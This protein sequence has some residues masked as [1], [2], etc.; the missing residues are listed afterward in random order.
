MILCPSAPLA[1]GALLFGLIDRR[2]H[3]SY[4]QAAVPVTR[5]LLL[6]L[7][8]AESA[9]R[10][11]RFASACDT[12]ACRHWA[13]GCALSAKLSELQVFASDS[14]STTSLPNCSIRTQCRWYLQDG[15]K[16]CSTCQVHSR[17]PG[18]VEEE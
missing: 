7:P 12:V 8:V 18:H 1:E 10:Q 4:S 13:D 16:M 3:V 11:F 17:L 9:E 14:E 5:K 6:Q 2:G 15:P